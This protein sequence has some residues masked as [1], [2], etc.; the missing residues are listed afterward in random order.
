MTS[1]YS[2]NA[3]NNNGTNLIINSE[4]ASALSADYSIDSALR[5]ER[6]YSYVEAMKDES[7]A[8][9]QLPITVSCQQ[10]ANIFDNIDTSEFIGYGNS[11]NNN[12]SNK[13]N[14]SNQRTSVTVYPQTNAWNS[15]AKTMT[16]TTVPITS[17]PKKTLLTN[18]TNTLPLS[19]MPS[20]SPSSCST[21]STSSNSSTFNSSSTIE[22]H[23]QATAKTNQTTHHADQ[24]LSTSNV[25]KSK[26][27]SSLLN[28]FKNTFSPF[29]IRKWRSKSRDKLSNVVNS[30][31]STI[32][33]NNADY[34][35]LSQPQPSDSRNRPN[36]K[37][38]KKY[39]QQQPSQQQLTNTN[40]NQIY[41][42]NSQKLNNIKIKTTKGPLPTPATS[43]VINTDEI[44]SN[45][46]PTKLLSS[47]KVFD[48]NG[49]N[50]T[51]LNNSNPRTPPT[52][53][54]AISSTDAKS[55]DLNY[56]SSYA[57][58]SIQDKCN[59]SILNESNQNATTIKANHKTQVKHINTND[60]FSMSSR[61]LDTT[62]RTSLQSSPQT[63][64]QA[65]YL[66][67]TCYLNGYDSFKNRNDSTA[68]IDKLSIDDQKREEKVQDVLNKVTCDFDLLENQKANEISQQHQ[69]TTLDTKVDETKVKD[70]NESIDTS[71]NNAIDLE[72]K[73][74]ANEIMDGNYYVKLIEINTAKILELCKQYESFTDESSSNYVTNEDA[75]GQIQTTIGKAHLLINQKF[76][77]FKGLCDKNMKH[78]IDTSDLKEGEFVTLDGDLA[79]FWDMVCL[80]IKD[81][82]SMFNMLNELKH[83][84]WSLEKL[85]S[86]NTNLVVTTKKNVKTPLKPL[87]P[88]NNTTVVIKSDT[89]R[90]A[91]KQR[92][93]EAKKNAAL[94]KQKEAA[95]LT[96]N[97][98]HNDC[99]FNSDVCVLSTATVNNI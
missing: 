23:N 9:V 5:L 69:E 63:E 43:I 8:G 42:K 32:T 72:T 16:T 79:G 87:K 48:A 21:G 92:L 98:I 6:N 51:T 66:K 22:S 80:Q 77:Q 44:D 40:S 25:S 29:T 85:K 2:N 61:I 68:T 31:S 91:A 62:P 89:A 35:P 59:A 39:Q 83:N 15:T 14:G 70:T 50:I 67:L 3:N 73:E 64:R 71:N 10:A 78:K 93:I 52:T 86:L 99:S 12:N 4:T 26:S 54:I 27:Q 34:S 60:M 1:F 11:S 55:T 47:S 94:I 38:A 74:I 65:S 30:T 20:S 81:I 17:F 33:S 56:C 58:R 45:N 41:L 53:T 7:C 90:L 46:N 95:L 75:L 49:N 28:L 13:S 18:V 96:T 97:N 88:S 76:K 37:Y 82:L 84:E 57:L 36:N 24:Q 19:S